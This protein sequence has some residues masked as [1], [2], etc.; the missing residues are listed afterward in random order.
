M[1]TT[2]NAQATT[3]LLTSADGS[4]IVQVQSNGKTVTALAWVNFNGTNGSIRSSYNVSSVSRTGTGAYTINFTNSISDTNYSAVSQCSQTLAGLNSACI[5]SSTVSNIGM[6]CGGI[7]GTTVVAT[8]PTSVSVAI[9][10]N[11]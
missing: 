10:G 3:G 6:Q 1:V 4:G 11:S 9:F 5:N 8:D 2:I 7:S